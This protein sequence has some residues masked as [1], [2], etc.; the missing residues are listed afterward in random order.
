MRQCSIVAFSFHEHI[1]RGAGEV[2]REGEGGGGTIRVET[3]RGHRDCVPPTGVGWSEST[4]RQK[5]ALLLL[6]LLQKQ[7]LH[8]YHTVHVLHACVHFFDP[9][10]DLKV[11]TARSA[12]L[13]SH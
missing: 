10:K 6:L 7:A 13:K 2:G 4:C 8:C 3:T 11:P 9:E 5:T 12:L 1:W